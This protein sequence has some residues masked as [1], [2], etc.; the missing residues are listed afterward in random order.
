MAHKPKPSSA[1]KPGSDVETTG[2]ATPVPADE[3]WRIAKIQA[4]IEAAD[5]G[6]FASDDEV[7]R[8]RRKYS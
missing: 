1:A 4:G 2:L 7:A 8:V 3:S 5:S 6:D